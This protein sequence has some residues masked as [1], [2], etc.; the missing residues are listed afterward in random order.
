MSPLGDLI[1]RG[2]TPFFSAKPA[3]IIKEVVKYIPGGVFVGY[4]K[5]E[6]P[7]AFCI[8]RWPQNS[9]ETPQ[10]L[11]FYSEGGHQITADLVSVVLDSVKAKGYNKLR[12]INGSGMDDEKWKRVFR[13]PDW[14]IN[15]VKTVF[16]FEVKA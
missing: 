2:M 7:V 15:P 13:H 8:V 12:A 1:V 4:D 11:H 3:E 16:D 14:N 10:V 9:I 5:T 6:A